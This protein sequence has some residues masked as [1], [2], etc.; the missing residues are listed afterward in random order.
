MRTSSDGLT[1]WVQSALVVVS[2]CPRCAPAMQIH[3]I[4]VTFFTCNDGPQPPRQSLVIRMS[5]ARIL[6]EAK[7]IVDRASRGRARSHLGTPNL[8]CRHCLLNGARRS[9]GL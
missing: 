4:A 5:W 6:S 8:P 1:R 7:G 9:G 2:V 3:G